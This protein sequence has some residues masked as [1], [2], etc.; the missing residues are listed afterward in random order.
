[1]KFV[2]LEVCCGSEKIVTHLFV[3]SRTIKRRLR[4]KKEKEKNN[5]VKFF[6]NIYSF[7]T[8]FFI[9]SNVKNTGQFF[10]VI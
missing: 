5:F 3:T 8:Q 7:E 1:M 6:I 10:R 4:N 9:L 2:K